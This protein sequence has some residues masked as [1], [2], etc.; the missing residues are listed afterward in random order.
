MRPSPDIPEG[1][2]LQGGYRIVRKIGEGGMGS[3]YEARQ[4]SLDRRVAIKV[5]SPM[6]AGDEAHLERFRR[7]ALASAALGHP[8]IV[9]VTDIQWDGRRAY[10]VM[11][12]LEGESLSDLL[13]KHRRLPYA[14]AVAIMS[15]VLAALHAAHDKGIV[16]RDLKPANV[17][18]V[19]IASGVDLAKL[20]DFGIAKLREG[21]GF[22]RLTATGAV[23]GTPQFL[24]P[25][26]AR[27]EPVDAR[28]DV[29]AAGTLLYLT[30][31][32]QLPFFHPHLAEMVKNICTKPPHP[33]STYVRGVPDALIGIIERSLAKDPAARFASAAEMKTALENYE[34]PDFDGGLSAE[35]ASAG[36]GPSAP[37]PAFQSVS[38]PPSAPP[39]PPVNLGG[40][41]DAL[42]P[43]PAPTV[44]ARPSSQSGSQPPASLHA[45]G[46]AHPAIDLRSSGDVNPTVDLRASGDRL[47]SAP[48]SRPS[49]A[50]R[51][52]GVGETRPHR[53]RR[54]LVVVLAVLG[55]L[56]V[57]GAVA[58]TL[59]V[60][61]AGEESPP[62]ADPFSEV[63]QGANDFLGQPS[64]LLTRES[65]ELQ[66]DQ[67]FA[68]YGD[69]WDVADATPPPPTGIAKCDSYAQ[70]VCACRTADKSHCGRARARI[71]ALRTRLLPPI[72]IETAQRAEQLCTEYTASIPAGC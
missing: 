46:D 57:V 41:A 31:A 9:Q 7:E 38:A 32:G 45:S 20:L 5:L 36:P 4:E 1:E 70:R 68:T 26:Q 65:V 27:G 71:E 23:V 25:E 67:I 44:G 3:V 69:K 13:K 22:K 39:A 58:V 56:S 6:L 8:N 33:M 11:E 42:P 72:T 12:L 34:S 60:I 61:F 63:V 51:P 16:H 59:L 2:T 43:G 55:L 49:A 37:P 29:F 28:T 62:P 15:Q 52:S 21:D 30:I 50:P 53:T 54:R 17:F 48:G 18:I 40:S 35:R 19:P 10:Y 64:G 24:A 47:P 14:R 66:A